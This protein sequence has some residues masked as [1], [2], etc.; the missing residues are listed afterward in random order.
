MSNFR[1]LE[2]VGRGSE[3]RLQVGENLNNMGSKGLI[4]NLITL[5]TVGFA[6][7]ICLT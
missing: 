5:L 4:W 6:F 7:R 1:P 2:I 3:T